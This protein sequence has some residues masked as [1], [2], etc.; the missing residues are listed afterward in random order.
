MAVARADL[1]AESLERPVRTQARLQLPGPP[2]VLY[3]GY[4]I[5]HPQL[6]RWLFAVIPCQSAMASLDQLFSPAPRR[7]RHHPYVPGRKRSSPQQPTWTPTTVLV[8][9]RLLLKIRGDPAAGPDFWPGVISACLSR[10]PCCDLSPR[11]SL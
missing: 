9:P 6:S 4:R 7:P 3:P 10:T 5:F 2:I 1:R 8:T 11:S